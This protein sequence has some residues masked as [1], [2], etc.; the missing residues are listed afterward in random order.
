MN[1]DFSFPMQLLSNYENEIAKPKLVYYQGFYM[2]IIGALSELPN[3]FQYLFLE[4]VAKISAGAILTSA[5][6]R[7]KKMGKF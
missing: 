7:Q 6:S 1:Q 4:S 3:K 5:F 2:Y